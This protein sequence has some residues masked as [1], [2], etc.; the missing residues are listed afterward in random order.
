MSRLS[1]ELRYALGVS[2]SVTGLRKQR[3]AARYGASR[4]MPSPPLPAT[5]GAG[6]LANAF[7]LHTA[8]PT[9]F[10]EWRELEWAS[11][12]TSYGRRVL[13]E[14]HSPRACHLSLQSKGRNAC[15]RNAVERAVEGGG[16]V[17]AFP[18]WGKRKRQDTNRG[19]GMCRT[20][21]KCL[22]TPAG[23]SIQF[24]TIV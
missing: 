16:R 21:L 17:N 19:G 10:R 6:G 24:S 1:A 13:R 5:L 7:S 22:K 11:H 20:L 8:A 15:P 12:G 2:G 9:C 3:Q 23:Y 18:M 14:K 4:L